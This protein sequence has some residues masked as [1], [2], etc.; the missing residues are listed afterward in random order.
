M[1]IKNCFFRLFC[2]LSPAIAFGAIQYAGGTYV[3]TTMTQDGTKQTLINA[4]VSNLNTAG[5]TTIAGLFSG[6]YTSGGSITGTAGQTCTL[7]AFN[8]GNSGGTATVALTG[9]NTI[10][11]GTALTITA[12]G[13][14]ST[15]ASTSATLGNG[16]ATCSGTATVAT[17]ISLSGTTNVLLRSATTVAGSL[18]MDLRL[19]DNGGNGVQFYLENTAFTLKPSTYTTSTGG[20]LLVTNALVYRVLATQYQTVIYSS[21]SATTSREFIWAGMPYLPTF[22]QSQVTTAGF[23]FSSA[24]SDGDSTIHPNLTNYPG[25]A[26]GSLDFQDNSG[27]LEVMVNSSYL[28]GTNLSTSSS[29]GVPRLLLGGIASDLDV[30]IPSPTGYRWSI[31]NA[32][33]TGDVLLAYGISTTTEAQVVG[34]IYDCFYLADSVVINTTMTFGGHTYITPTNS[35]S[36]S[37]SHAPRGG[38]WFSTN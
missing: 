13:T 21:G 24:N 3:N 19:K 11:G 32:V 30:T 37:A 7:T 12:I 5:W 27:Y 20:T 28:E 17:V 35:F 25:I 1:K 36:G 22:Q 33:V 16:T 38:V 2:F 34:Q 10:A 4:V 9:A 14:G 29:I 6:T 31:T 8:N 18:Q 15:S 23:M 26:N